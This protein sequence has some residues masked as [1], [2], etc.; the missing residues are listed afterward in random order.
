[1]RRVIAVCPWPCAATRIDTDWARWSGLSGETAAS[2]W[3]PPRVTNTQDG[4]LGPLGSSAQSSL[5]GRPVGRSLPFLRV[6]PSRRCRR[7]HPSSSPSSSRQLPLVDSDTPEMEDYCPISI[8]WGPREGSPRLHHRIGGGGRPYATRGSV[9]SRLVA[10]RHH[11]AALF[12]YLDDPVIP[13]RSWTNHC[14]RT[15]S[16]GKPCPGRL[17]PGALGSTELCGGGTSRNA[18]RPPCAACTCVWETTLD[19]PPAGPEGRRTAPPRLACLSALEHKDEA[20]RQGRS[21]HV[22]NCQ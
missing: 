11:R 22:T 10:R 8:P 17:A 5:A 13:V 4:G 3:R 19:S 18:M 20:P 9:M 7:W 2:F 1:M 12:P 21:S 6:D 15:G 14:S 16:R